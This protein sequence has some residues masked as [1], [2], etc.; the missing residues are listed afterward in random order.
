MPPRTWKLGFAWLWLATALPAAAEPLAIITHASS[1][2]EEISSLALRRAYLGKLTRLDGARL[3]PL[4]L[5][6]GTQARRAFSLSVL[7][8]SEE[9]L[10]GYWIEQALR[11]GRLPPRELSSVEQLIEQVARRP[12]AI[13]Y[14]PLSAVPGDAGVRVLRLRTGTRSLEPDDAAYPIQAATLP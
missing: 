2:G 13:G 5:G 6:S 12:G 3:E 11:G 8:R 10:Q 9:E 1:R 4:H 7:G 14:V